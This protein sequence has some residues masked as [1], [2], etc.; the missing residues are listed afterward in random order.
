MSIT[1]IQCKMLMNIYEKLQEFRE[2]SCLGQGVTD[3]TLN[4]P[5]IHIYFFSA[6]KLGTLENP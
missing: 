2:I 3:C 6:A 5:R 1:C 4:Y